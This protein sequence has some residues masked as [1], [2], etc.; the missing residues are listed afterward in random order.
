MPVEH[1]EGH[2]LLGIGDRNQ[3][4][5]RA[6]NH[7]VEVLD[8]LDAGNPIAMVLVLPDGDVQVAVIAVL[9]LLL[10]RQ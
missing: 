5:Q 4:V 7:T 8:V 10:I 9:I 6:G 2:A 1:F 3:L